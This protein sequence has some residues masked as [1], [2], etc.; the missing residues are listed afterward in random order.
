M[1]IYA[2]GNQADIHELAPDTII[3]SPL[4]FW[5]PSIRKMIELWYDHKV[6]GTAYNAPKDKP[7]FF[8]MKD[9]GSGLAPFYGF[10]QKLP[11]E[12]LDKVKSVTQDIMDGKLV[13]PLKLDEVKGD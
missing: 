1:G 2:F 8:L 10:E 3:T 4:F 13:I 6:N 12:V 11:K 5:D 7:T 9:G